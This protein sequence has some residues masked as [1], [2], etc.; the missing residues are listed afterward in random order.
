[1]LYDFPP[2]T[3]KKI[4]VFLESQCYD[5]L[6]FWHK[7]TVFWVKNGYFFAECF[8]DNIFKFGNAGVVV[9]NSKVVRS[10][11]RPT[12]ESS[13]R[14]RSKERLTGESSF[15]FR[16]K[17]RLTGE[18][19]FRFRSKNRLTHESSFRFRWCSW[20]A[21]ASRCWRTR[22]T[23]SRWPAS[24]SRPS[25]SLKTKSHIQGSYSETGNNVQICLPYCQMFF[26]YM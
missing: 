10:K 8:G 3:A 26:T 17:E 19:S 2:I 25:R 9:V 1:M 5:Q 24:R 12:G 7:R 16:S 20:W 13:F 11:K 21:T 15:R 23:R 18:S 14:F 4:G 6:F 22:T